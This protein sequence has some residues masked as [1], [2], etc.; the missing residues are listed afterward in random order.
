[1]H[2]AVAGNDTCNGNLA[3]PICDQGHCNLAGCLHLDDLRAVIGDI[4]Q[5][6]HSSAVIAETPAN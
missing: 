3:T 2:Y 1:M 6:P 5:V 4:T